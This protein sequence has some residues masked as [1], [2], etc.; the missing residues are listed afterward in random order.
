MICKNNFKDLCQKEFN[1]AECCVLGAGSSLLN[2]EKKSFDNMHCFAVNSAIMYLDWEDSGKYSRF[3]LS[4]DALCLR[5]TYWDKVVRSKCNIVVRDSWC[6]YSDILPEN[7]K[8]FKPRSSNTDLENN[9]DDGLCFCSSVPTCIDMALQFGFKKIYLYGVDHDSSD[10]GYFWDK[11]KTEH[12]PRQVVD[13]S[14]DRKFFTQPLALKQPLDQRI[15][16]WEENMRCFDSLEK[17]SNI[18]NA[19]IVNMNEKSS[20]KS[21]KFHDAGIK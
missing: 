20:V 15:K 12:K 14:K 16:V 2:F 9:S 4:N 8:F 13:F 18:F 21:F 11:W 3:W 7:V 5:W 17:Y 10:V 6:K 19:S 1:G